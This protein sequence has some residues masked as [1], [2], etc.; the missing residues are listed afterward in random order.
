MSKQTA[1][2]SMAA[3]SAAICLAA[4]PVEAAPAA[5][6]VKATAASSLS[7]EQAATVRFS[8]LTDQDDALTR[9]IHDFL[10]KTR[11]VDSK[12]LGTVANQVSDYMGAPNNPFSVRLK[13]GAWL[14]SGWHPH[15][16]GTYGVAL[17]DKEGVMRAAGM[18]FSPSNGALLVFQYWIYVK[19]SPQ[20]EQYISDMKQIQN[21]KL[22]FVKPDMP[23]KVITIP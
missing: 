14:V 12:D 6:S 16:G 22:S 4:Q 1:Q 20:S 8:K 3:W 17:I 19:A 23:V 18:H 9:Q 10:G 15:D 7:R 11:N 21:L 13:D 2:I 5:A